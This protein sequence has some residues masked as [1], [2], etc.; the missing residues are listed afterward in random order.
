MSYGEMSARRKIRRNDPR[1]KSRTAKCPTAKCPYGEVSLQRNV[2]RRNVPTEKCLYGKTAKCSTT[3]CPT[4]KNPKVK[5][6]VTVSMDCKLHWVSLSLV[7]GGAGRLT[8]TQHFTHWKNSTAGFTYFR[9]VGTIFRNFSIRFKIYKLC[10][11][12]FAFCILNLVSNSAIF[13]S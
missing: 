4:A 11:T 10:D 12:K 6:P 3:K 7:R 1:R 9:Q 5:C 13:V 2:P 8:S